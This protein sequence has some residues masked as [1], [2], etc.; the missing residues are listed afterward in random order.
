MQAL[1]HSQ[2]PGRMDLQ[3]VGGVQDDPPVAQLVAGPLDDQAAVRGQRPGGLLLVGQ[4]PDQVLPGP[5]IHAQALQALPDSLVLPAG[6]DLADE[7]AQGTAELRG[8]AQAVAAP[9]RQAGR[10]AEGRGDQHTVEGDLF[11]P[12]AAGAQREDVAHPRFVDHLLIQLTHAPASGARRPG[13][14]G[15]LRL[16]RTHQVDPEE[17]P[18]RNGSAGC[19]GQALSPGTPA[20]SAGVAVPD[21]PRP[22]VSEP[23]RG[24]FPGQQ[25]QH[26]LIGRARQRGEGGRTAQ[27][28]EPL[29]N[30][31]TV[32]S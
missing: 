20:Q 24:V 13:D 17:P 10:L 16:L 8:A 5:L 6:V 7:A 23:V 31:Q 2:R 27:R 12:P 21:D 29:L 3:P 14:G 19:D 30:I 15:A 1:A 18:I 32:Q 26:R 22:Q 11:D 9:E 28:L 4:I 25:V